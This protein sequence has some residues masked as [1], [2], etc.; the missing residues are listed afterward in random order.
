MITAN[1]TGNTIKAA[2]GYGHYAKEV[3]TKAEIDSKFGDIIINGKTISTSLNGSSALL[4]KSGAKKV[5]IEDS[6]L[7][8]S[9]F[10]SRGKLYVCAENYGKLFGSTTPCV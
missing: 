8:L 5:F 6:D 7:Y 9:G 10:S 2:R 3:Y 1:I 4:L